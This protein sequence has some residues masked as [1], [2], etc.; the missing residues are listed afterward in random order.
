MREETLDAI[1]GEIDSN[2][3]IVLSITSFPNNF[4]PIVIVKISDS[5]T[6]RNMTDVEEPKIWHA[7]QG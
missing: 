7:P 3:W 1:P 4:Y 5:R 6:E 2:M